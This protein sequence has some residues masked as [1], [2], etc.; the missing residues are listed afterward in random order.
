MT[1]LS[2]IAIVAG[3]GIVTWLFWRAAIGRPL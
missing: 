2:A 3:G 1:G